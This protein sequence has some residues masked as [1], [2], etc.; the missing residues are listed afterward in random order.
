MVRAAVSCWIPIE[1]FREHLNRLPGG[2]LTTTDV[3]QRLRAFMEESFHSYPNGELREGCL[4]LY[5]REKA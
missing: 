2:R 3:E 4:A 1:D 5:E